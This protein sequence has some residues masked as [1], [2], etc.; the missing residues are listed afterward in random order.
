M[1]VITI[2]IDPELHLGPVTLAWHGLTI[3]LGIVIGAIVAGRWLRERGRDV[4]PLYTIAAL[5]AL[6]GIVGARVFYLLEHDPGALLAPDRLIGSNGYTFDGGIILAAVIVA[7]YVRRSRLG[8]LYLDAC[9][10]G[11]GLGVAIGRVGDVINGEHYGDRST[12][13][14]A[15]RNSHPDALTPNP[16]LAYHNGGLYEVLL[17]TAIF[18][19]VWPLRHRLKRTGDVA[20]LVLGLL[21]AGR[22]FVFFLR[23]DSPQL[24]LG[25]SNA[26]W[27]SVALLL[28]V[29]VGRAFTSR[30]ANVQR[31]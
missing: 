26:Q 13:L 2:G 16:D 19:V 18:A 24:A 9:A 27:T 15:V 5:A 28:V 8:A 11:L 30:R 21:A 7:L 25:L 20:W 31:G 29:V 12:S 4:E 3:A 22:F 1:A 17:A 10:A 23:S 14:L 6:G